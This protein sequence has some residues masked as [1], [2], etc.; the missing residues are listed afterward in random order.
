M[1]LQ[2]VLG[3]TTALEWFS[4]GLSLI[5]AYQTNIHEEANT[6]YCQENTSRN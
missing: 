6:N 5:T 3:A 2:T 4:K 1:A